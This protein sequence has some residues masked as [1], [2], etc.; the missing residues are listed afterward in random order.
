MI[1]FLF[2]EEG[3][4]AYEYTILINNYYE[5]GIEADT[6]EDA[7]AVVKEF[8]ADDYPEVEFKEIEILEK[9]KIN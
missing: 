7:I 2:D 5:Y 1:Q 3:V 4:F 8:F 6:D 9:N